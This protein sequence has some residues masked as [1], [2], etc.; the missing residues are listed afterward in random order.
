M[1]VSCIPRSDRTGRIPTARLHIRC[2]TTA[3]RT[4]HTPTQN[5]QNEPKDK[6]A[7]KTTGQQ[8]PPRSANIAPKP[9]RN[10]RKR[11]SSEMLLKSDPQSFA[12][13]T[14][15]GDLQ[16][17]LYN[18][19]EPRKCNK[20]TGVSRRGYQTFGTFR[21]TYQAFPHVSALEAAPAHSSMPMMLR[22]WVF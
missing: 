10:A 12:L 20:T 22:L 3:K 6:V 17:L 11:W 4:R 15:R 1:V 16:E 9:P 19:H 8:R 14:V 5:T 18:H 21:F 7:A 13:A 2:K